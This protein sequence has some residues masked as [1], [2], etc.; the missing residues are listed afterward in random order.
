MWA[1]LVPG[2]LKAAKYILL[3]N[4]EDITFSFGDFVPKLQ[5]VAHVPLL[6]FFSLSGFSS[7]EILVYLNLLKYLIY[8]KPN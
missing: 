5:Y 6:Q 7:G 4:Y 3:K 8:K 1:A 2:E